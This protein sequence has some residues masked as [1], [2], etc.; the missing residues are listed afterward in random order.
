MDITW[1]RLKNSRLKKTRGVSFEDLIKKGKIIK[2][3]KHPKRT[4]QKIMLIE[5]KKYIWVI[6]YIKDASGTIF[7][8]T[9]FQSRKYTKLFKEG[10]L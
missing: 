9:L 10:I 4:S 7:L 6:P 2:I 3:Q 5:Y 1:D 8:K